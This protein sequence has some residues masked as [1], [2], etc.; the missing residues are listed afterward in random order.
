MN[1]NKTS[2]ARCLS[3]FYIRKKK[4]NRE[5]YYLFQNTMSVSSPEISLSSSSSSASKD[6]N[7]YWE[8]NP[9]PVSSHLSSMDCWDYTIELECLK[10]PEG[11]YLLMFSLWF[12]FSKLK[13]P[14]QYYILLLSFLYH[15]NILWP[16]E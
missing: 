9:T 4:N 6:D 16:N 14:D 12:S 11:G 1:T 2:P 10:G 5:K 7:E 13:T 3:V 8:I 15:C